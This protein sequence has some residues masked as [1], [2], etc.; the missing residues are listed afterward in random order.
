VSKESSLVLALNG[1]VTMSNIKRN[2]NKYKEVLTSY[3][4]PT[5]K[6]G[7]CLTI[8]DTHAKL[9][10]KIGKFGFFYTAVL[11]R[12]IIQPTVI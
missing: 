10:G 2:K 8:V 11:L 5:L 1:Y 6:V 7:A 12:R 9:H 3:S 4:T